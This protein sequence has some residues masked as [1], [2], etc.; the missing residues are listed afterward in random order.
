MLNMGLI[1]IVIEENASVAFRASVANVARAALA[2]EA[3][4]HKP[5]P[6]GTSRWILF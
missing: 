4:E 2:A 5:L 6:K 1:V 3:T